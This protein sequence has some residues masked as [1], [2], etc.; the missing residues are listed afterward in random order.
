M[1]IGFGTDIVGL[2]RIQKILQRKGERFKNT[3]FTLKEQAYCDGKLTPFKNYA[4]R[5]A[6]KE[7]LLKAIGTGMREGI[8]WQDIEILPDS[9]GCP[10]VSVQGGVKKLLD[11]KI[12]GS[13]SANILIS[14]SDDKDYAIAS[15]M[16]EAI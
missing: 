13:M 2:D 8:S 10:I 12:S 14:L 15:V 5:Y 6:G 11:Q 7:A 3:I 9:L 16:I 1:I 4:M